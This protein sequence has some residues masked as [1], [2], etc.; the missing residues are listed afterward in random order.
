MTVQFYI[1]ADNMEIKSRGNIRGSMV[2]KSMI[3]ETLFPKWK[4]QLFKLLAVWPSEI[5]FYSI[6]ISVSASIKPF[7]DCGIKL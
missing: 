5:F 3:S 7:N 2:I 1:Q 6:W 4:S